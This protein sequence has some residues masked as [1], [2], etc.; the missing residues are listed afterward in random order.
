MG[1]II[2]LIKSYYHYYKAHVK[3]WKNYRIIAV[4]G[5]TVNLINSKELTEAFGGQINQNCFFTTAKTFYCYDVLNELILHSQIG[6]YSIGE[7][8][9]AYKYID[10]IEQDMLMIYDRNF[11]NY[12]MIALHQWQEKERK[13]I[14]RGNENHTFITDFITSKK[15]STIFYMKPTATTI[16]NLKKS[17]YTINS[18]TLLKVRLV[19]VDLND[20]VEVLITNLWQEE[21]Y[22]TNDFKDLYFKRWAIETNISL[23]KNILQ[24]EAFSG[25]TSKAVMQDFYATVLMANLQSIITKDAQETVEKSTVNRKYKMKINR[26]KSMGKI[27]QYWILLLTRRKIK[28]LLKLL[29]QHFVKELIPIR[30]G[31]SFIRQVKNRRSNSKYRTYTNFKPAF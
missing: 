9:M 15:S 11:C 2:V 10:T 18:K 26:N 20:K 22:K 16:R 13:Y 17:G 12:K 25:L 27:K 31:R 7:L 5:S 19:R 30:N 8:T 29:H 1:Y 3:R 24:L 4:D 14:I 6:S 28:D 23:Q 21:G